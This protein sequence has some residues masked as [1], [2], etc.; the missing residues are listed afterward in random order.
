M[1]LATGLSIVNELPR[2]H[3]EVDGDDYIY[4]KNLRTENKFSSITIEVSPSEAQSLVYILSTNP[5]SLFLS[6]LTQRIM[7]LSI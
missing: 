1:I 4:T 5:S 2:I 7:L 6:L 3:E